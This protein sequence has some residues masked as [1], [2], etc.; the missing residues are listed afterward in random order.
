METKSYGKMGV[1]AG[2]IS[3][4][5]PTAGMY[6]LMKD[7]Q[8]RRRADAYNAGFEQSDSDAMEL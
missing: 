2:L 3:A 8:K 1:K 7:L 4:I 5:N 6:S